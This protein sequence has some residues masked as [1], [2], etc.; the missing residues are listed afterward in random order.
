MT[1]V[2]VSCASAGTDTVMIDGGNC[3][4]MYK[5]RL[6]PP[7]HLT[8][9]GAFTTSVESR[10][11]GEMLG[12]WEGGAHPQKIGCVNLVAEG[13][14]QQREDVLQYDSHLHLIL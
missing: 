6:I 7:N 1:G 2:C 11:Q 4:L 13:A 8:D 3:Q 14:V 9:G 10:L 5:N 12:R